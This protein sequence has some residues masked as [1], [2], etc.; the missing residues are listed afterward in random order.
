MKIP[1]RTAVLLLNGTTHLL[2]DLPVSDVVLGLPADI[3]DDMPH[4]EGQEDSDEGSE[5]IQHDLI[6]KYI[7]WSKELDTIVIKTR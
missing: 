4:L 3:Y 6:L 2:E 5:I 1:R 7:C